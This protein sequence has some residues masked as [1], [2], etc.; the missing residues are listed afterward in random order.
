MTDGA[1][2][3]DCPMSSPRRGVTKSRAARECQLEAL[4]PTLGD[5]ELEV[6]LLV[7]TRL[8]NGQRR[9]GRFELDRDRRDFG[10]EA[11]EE[12]ADALVY[13]G[14]ALVRRRQ[15]ASLRRRGHWGASR[16]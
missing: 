12:V 10:R 11:L 2:R 16:G 1:H 7:V 8:W 13:S 3:A 5:D 9:Y 15:R 6:L 4:V 14:V